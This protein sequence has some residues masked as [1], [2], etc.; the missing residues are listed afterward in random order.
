MI[1]PNPSSFELGHPYSCDSLNVELIIDDGPSDTS[2][3]PLPPALR[4]LVEY[5]RDRQAN[6]T[7]VRRPAPPSP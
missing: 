4:A 5:E 1:D 2:V 3:R 6:P 7:T